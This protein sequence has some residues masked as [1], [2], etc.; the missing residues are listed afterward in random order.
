[1]MESLRNTLRQHLSKTTVAP[2]GQMGLF[3]CHKPQRLHHVPIQQA[4]LVMVLSG[5]KRMHIHNTVHTCKAGQLLLI[6]ANTDIRIEN[7]PDAQQQEYLALCVSFSTKTIDA[8]LHNYADQISWKDHNAQTLSAKPL[9]DELLKAITQR[10]ELCLNGETGNTVINDLRQQELLAICADH[11]WLAT[12]LQSK[13]SSTKQQV[14]GIIA[15]DLSHEWRLADICQKLAISESTLR[16]QLHT[17]GSSFRDILEETRLLSALCLL[18]ETPIAIT[19]LAAKVGYQSPSRFSANF[20]R[21][22]GLSPSEL[23]LSRQPERLTDNTN[24]ADSDVLLN[25]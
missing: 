2:L 13:Q 14:A 19:T 18:Q 20:K 8:F 21:R 5:E 3:H 16:R 17:E 12:L 22:F 15:M 10:V 4:T 9:S 24:L 6:P 11:H 1:M 7:A 23:K 25:V